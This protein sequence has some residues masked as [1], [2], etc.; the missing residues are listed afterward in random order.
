M[1][2]LINI[3]PTCITFFKSSYSLPE[4]MITG[5]RTY[6]LLTIAKNKLASLYNAFLIWDVR[7]YKADNKLNQ[8]MMHKECG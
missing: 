7:Y 3:N 8:R 1:N 5:N 4:R 2:T 6:I